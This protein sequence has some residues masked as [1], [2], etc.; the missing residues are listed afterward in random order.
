M[1]R[2]PC[3]QRYD[4]FHVVGPRQLMVSVNVFMKNGTRSFM[5]ANII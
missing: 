5:N 2:A 1:Q 4:V 3:V